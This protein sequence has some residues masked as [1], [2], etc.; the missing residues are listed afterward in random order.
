MEGCS[1]DECTLHKGQML[2]FEASFLANQDTTHTHFDVKAFLGEIPL[3]VPLKDHDGCKHLKC[4]LKKGEVYVYSMN[5][6]L[7]QFV[8]T[9]KN[10]RIQVHLYGDSGQMVCVTVSHINIE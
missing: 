5:H 1:G 6:T 2:S 4:P 7:P 8:P 10:G 3:P 9:V